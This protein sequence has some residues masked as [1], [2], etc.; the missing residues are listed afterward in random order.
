MIS[1]IALLVPVL[2]GCEAGLNAPTLA[3]HPAANG[4][5]AVVNDISINNVFVLGPSIGSTISAGGSAGLFLAL[6]NNG[7][8]S[9]SLVGVSAP[10][11]ATSVKLEKGTVELTPASSQLLTGPV[12]DVVLTGLTQPLT[13][14]KTIT[15]TLNFAT[16]GAVTLRVPVEPHDYYYGTLSPAPS[17][18]ASATETASPKATAT[19]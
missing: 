14:G 5:H 18:A 12:P 19:K 16:T 11:T 8:Q 15:I 9:D 10:G 4:A 3:F 2:A 17:A 13:A 6:Y 1:V 7:N